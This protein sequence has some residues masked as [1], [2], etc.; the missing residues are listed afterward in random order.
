M[1]EPGCT[2]NYVNLK[3]GS[4]ANLHLAKS[5]AGVRYTYGGDTYSMSYCSLFVGTHTKTLYNGATST[6]ISNITNCT[7]SP[8][9]GS[10]YST[11]V[12]SFALG[13]SQFAFGGFVG[14]NTA[15]LNI[16]NCFIDYN[17]EIGTNGSASTGVRG[18][19]VGGFV[20]YAGGG[21]STSLKITDCMSYVAFS[22]TGVSSTSYAPSSSKY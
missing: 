7:I 21:S 11:C 6:L 20:G 17:I 10:S 16:A 14:I 3:V 18:N 2:L 13:S 1:L 5:S 15:N 19:S 9:D 22:V 8:V 4:L 12:L